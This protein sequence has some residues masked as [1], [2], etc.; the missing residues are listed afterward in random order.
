MFGDMFSWVGNVGKNS[1]DWASKAAGKIGAVGE[2][3]VT[4]AT[5]ISTEAQKY[6]A[7]LAALTG[8]GYSQVAAEQQLATQERMRTTGSLMGSEFL[9]NPMN[10]VAIAGIIAVIFLLKK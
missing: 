10:I 2:K 9:A 7:K 8:Q 6:A 5:K 3:A 1:F 4:T